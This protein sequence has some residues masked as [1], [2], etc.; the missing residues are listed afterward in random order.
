MDTETITR[1]Q[2]HNLLSKSQAHMV[3]DEA[4]KNYPMSQINTLFPNGEYSA[5]A[6][7]EHIRIAQNDILVFIV[8]PN[9]VY[10]EWPKD[11]WPAPGTKATP[12][13][14][15]HTIDLYHADLKTLQDMA[16]NPATDLYAKIPHGTGQNILRE[17]L[18]VA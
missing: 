12:V 15:Q 3:I 10:L 6:L 8:N 9:Y 1:E 4:V 18:L 13:D 7:L 16:M 5:W 17:L 14:W 2:L 11:Y